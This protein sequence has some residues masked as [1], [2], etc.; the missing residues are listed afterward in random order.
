MKTSVSAFPGT[1][2]RI[3]FGDTQTGSANNGTRYLSFSVGRTH[4][5]LMY[6][7]DAT[8]GMFGIGTSN[9]LARLHVDGGES[10]FSNTT[11]IWA[12]TPSTGGTAGA[13]NSLEIIDRVNNKRR[14]VFNDNGDVSL[15]GIVLA[16]NDQGVISIRGTKVGIGLSGV[17]SIPVATLDVQGTVSVNGASTNASS[18]A[19]GNSTTIDFSKSNL[20][21]TNVNPGNTFTLQ[22]VKDGGTYTLLVQGTTSGT[23]IF[24][25]S[26]FNVKSMNNGPTANGKQTLYTFIVMGTSV[27]VSMTTGF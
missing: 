11:S 23:A 3:N 8:R 24:S 7:K 18:Y 25:A 14:M 9:P 10:R 1:I 6:L 19:A 27:F 4:T 22:N 20:A 15:G 17:N 26:G 5:E 13:S 12:L 16:N 21:Y 2:S